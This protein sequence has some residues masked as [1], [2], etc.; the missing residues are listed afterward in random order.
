MKALAPLIIL[1]ASTLL[2]GCSYIKNWF[3]DKEKDYQ[4]TVEI[5]ELV[6]P[7]NLNAPLSPLIPR[8]AEIRPATPERMP[9][10]ATPSTATSQSSE[11]SIIAP[12]EAPPS[13]QT[14]TAQHITASIDKT[15]TQEPILRLNVRF[16]TAW[17]ALDKALSRHSFEVTQRNKAEKNLT[18]HYDPTEKKLEDGSFWN[19]L[20]FIFHGFGSDEHTYV[21]QLSEILEQTQIQVL[22]DQKQAVTDEDAV[23]LL[24]QLQHSIASDTP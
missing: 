15:S 3:P 14:E 5:P 10:D 6:L 17:R 8:P 9:N 2:P 1:L 7:D 24:H 19:E 16:N 12:T 4:Y 18:I 23:H 21:L 13:T 11:N 22:N 20:T